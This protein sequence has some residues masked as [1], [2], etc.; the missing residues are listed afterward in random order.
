MPQSISDESDYM[1]DPDF[2][3]PQSALLT[4]LLHHLH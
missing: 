2:K 4:E 3:R 1:F